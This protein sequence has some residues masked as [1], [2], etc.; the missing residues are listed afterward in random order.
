PYLFE[1]FRQGDSSTTRQHEGLGLGLALVKYLTELHGGTVSAYSLGSGKGATFTVKL[2]LTIAQAPAVTEPGEHPTAALVARAVAPRPPS[3]SRRTDASR[4][5]C[6]RFL[7][8]TACTCPS[9]CSPS[10]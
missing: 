4:I 8:A 9:R 5:A 1:R 7:R 3:R 2:P 6:A 10:S